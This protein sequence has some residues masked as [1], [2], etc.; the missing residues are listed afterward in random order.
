MPIDLDKALGAELEPI[1]FSWTSSDIQLYHLGLG[2]GA[3]PMDE[4]ELRYLVDDT[5]QVLPTFGNVAASFHMTE[6]PKVQ[7]PGIDIELSK[8]L[9]ASEAVSVPG[10]IPTSGTAKSVQRF[11]EIWDK[12][13]AAVIV[14][15]STVTDESGKVLWTTKR[16]IFARGEG[17]FGGERGPS[18]SVEMPDRAPDVEISLPTLPQQA[19]LYRLCGDRNPLHSDPAFAKAAGFDRPILHGLCTYGIGCKAIVDN[20]LDGDVSQVASYGARFAGV[21]IPGETLQAN[22]WKEDGKF[23]GVLTAPSR[24]NAVVLSGVELVPA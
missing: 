19:L 1:E 18:T 12:G 3:D 23:I 24:D 17:G 11:T 13:K 22:V 2:A 6:P 16:S 4:R 21:V 20:L 15:E 5:P 9:H 7:F 14:S 10:P 8:V